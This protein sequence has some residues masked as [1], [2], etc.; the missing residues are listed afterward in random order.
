[1]KTSWDAPGLTCGCCW[2]GLTRYAGL[3]VAPTALCQAVFNAD[4]QADMAR[5]SLPC[6]MQQATAALR[7]SYVYLLTF[8][9]LLATCLSNTCHR[10]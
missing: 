7:P 5:R 9:M 3:A 4:M 10:F 1:M 8:A 2:L 6:L